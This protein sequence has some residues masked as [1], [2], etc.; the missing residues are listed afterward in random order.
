[1]NNAYMRFLDPGVSL[2]P[3]LCHEMPPEQRPQPSGRMIKYVIRVK[4]NPH[5]APT[6]SARITLDGL[7][8]EADRRTCAS[9]T[10]S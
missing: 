3:A 5:L 8:A 2:C 7:V 4:F 1:M 10:S 6:C 9:A